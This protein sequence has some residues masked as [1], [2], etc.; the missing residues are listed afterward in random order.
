CP[1]P[2]AIANT[3]LKRLVEHHTFSQPDKK[4]NAHI[5]VPFLADADRLKH[6]RKLLYLVV[7]LRCAYAHAARVERGIRPAM[8]DDPA[9]R[10]P[11][12]EIAVAPHT[13]ETVEIG[14]S[15][16]LAG[17]LG[18]ERNWHGRKGSGANQRPPSRR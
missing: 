18:P 15:V 13:V 2:D 17:R 9:V 8:N 16:F 5:A 7:D 4:H 12:G 1:C 6:L 10:R 3:L 14:G 11:L